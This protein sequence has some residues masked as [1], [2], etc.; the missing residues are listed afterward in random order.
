VRLA[1]LLRLCIGSETGAAQAPEALR[2]FL[3]RQCD[4]AS[5]SM[6]E[7]TLKERQQSVRALFRS[8]MS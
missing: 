3:A 4:V 2:A 6:L 8:V 7:A 1:Q 5:F